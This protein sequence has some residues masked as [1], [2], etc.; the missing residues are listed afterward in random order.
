MA[1]LASPPSRALFV[2]ACAASPPGA[3]QITYTM[4]ILICVQSR[5]SSRSSPDTACSGATKKCLVEASSAMPYEHLVSS[6]V[7][8]VFIGGKRFF[9]AGIRVRF[10]SAQC[11]PSEEN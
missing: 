5:A 10:L 6:G 11:E 1:R 9:Q 2:T 3:S 8:R 4:Q 7:E